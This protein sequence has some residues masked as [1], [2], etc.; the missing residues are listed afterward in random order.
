[1]IVKQGQP[2]AK[3]AAAAAGLISI[4]MPAAAYAGD[5]PIIGP[6]P[7]W[8]KPLP[9]AGGTL[10]KDPP[11][12]LVLDRQINV[13]G[14]MITVYAH[15]SSRVA[16]AETLTAASTLALPWHPDKGDLTIHRVNLIRSGQVIDPLAKGQSFSVLRRESNLEQA[17]INGILTATMQIEGVQVGDVVEFE[18]S[19]SSVD[20][21]LAGRVNNFT[22]ISLGAVSVG[23]SRLRLVWDAKRKLTWRVPGI[24]GTVKERSA[25]GQ[26]EV[27]LIAPFPELPKMPNDA[28]MRYQIPLALEASDFV[29]WKDVSRVAA[30]LYEPRA[31]DLTDAALQKEV[32]QIASKSNDP[33]VRAADALRLVQDKVR[34]LFNGMAEGNYTP[35]SASDTWSRR[36]GDCKAKTLLLLTILRQLGVEAEPALVNARA[37]DWVNKLLPGF[38]AFDH[39]VVRAR[40]AD[41]TYWLD[42]TQLGSRLADMGD[43]PPFIWALP[44]RR[45]GAELERLMS[46]PPT[47]QLEQTTV[48]I[49]ATAGLAFPAPYKASITVRGQSNLILRAAQSA[50][51][52]KDFDAMLDEIVA[53]A[54]NDGSVISRSVRFDD[55]NGTAIIEGSGLANMGWKAKDGRQQSELETA[56]STF[57][58]DVDRSSPDQLDTPVSVA[59]P[60]FA[61]RTVTI[62]LPDNGKGYTLSGPAKMSASVIGVTFE[63][64]F[65]LDGATATFSE[66]QIATKMEVPAS[67]LGASRADLVKAQANSLAIVAPATYP[68]RKAEIAAAR[69][70]G[71]LKPLIDAYAAGIAQAREDDISPL[72]D[73]ARFYEGIEETAL[74][75]KDLDRSLLVERDASTLL[76]RGRLLAKTDQAK[77]IKDILAAQELEPDSQ[78]AL[79]QLVGIRVERKEFDL[80]LK[81]IAD[82]QASGGKVPDMLS[83]RATV[84]E[85]SGKI[86]DAL[87]E[88]GKAIVAAPGDADLLNA[89]CWMKATNNKSLESA[90]KDCTK[91]IA[92]LEEPEEALDSRG[93]VFFRL[94]KFDDAISD[95]DAALKIKPE[96]AEPRFVRGLAKLSKGD[97]AG[98]QEDLKAALALKSE[99]SKT[100][101]GYGI[102]V[103][104]L[105]AP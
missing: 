8:V 81:D 80:A 72:Q 12:L 20:S 102:T 96:L 38:Q 66:T 71:Q 21:A 67:I 52:A 14:P 59:F 32:T 78:D 50:A 65:R 13:S 40:I 19:I 100:Y 68:G 9:A 74:A 82:V 76:W 30:A 97:I 89:L 63:S 27:E 49:D 61:H 70:A 6:R 39:I 11:Q 44:L 7:A 87:A 37:G 94:N 83:L 25:A 29:D 91:A 103:P 42:G 60:Q 99:L 104:A 93:L 84:L 17:Q 90:L 43:V 57:D 31:A 10:A 98:G 16:S 2:V 69:K 77:A 55:D 1:M 105:S 34:Y 46:G 101:A 54:I 35:S 62:K 85:K 24:L 22:P 4:V 92:L 15:I 58:L 56:V 88:L 41:Q 79:E 26:K 47:R 95:L 64:D 23:Q 75:I 28:P 53:G 86:D 3:L 36:Y 48:A 45:E 51:T 18:F 33:K 73:R 5:K